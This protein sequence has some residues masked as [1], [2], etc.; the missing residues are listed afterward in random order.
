MLCA[1]AF[2]ERKPILF[3]KVF[4]FATFGVPKVAGFGAAPR[5]D[6]SQGQ[7]PALLSLKRSAPL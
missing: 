5:S 1:F 3:V 7:R 2:Y 6:L 4:A